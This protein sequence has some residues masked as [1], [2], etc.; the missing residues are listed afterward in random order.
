MSFV[1]L[2]HVVNPTPHHLRQPDTS[3]SHRGT[4]SP[5][6]YTTST[7]RVSPGDTALG[8]EARVHERRF[9]PLNWAF[10]LQT[11]FTYS[12][13]TKTLSLGILRPLRRITYNPAI[14]PGTRL[15]G[16]HVSY[17]PGSAYSP[18]RRQHPTI[19]HSSYRA[20][21][22]TP[23]AHGHKLLFC[24]KVQPAI[25][26]RHTSA[27][28]GT[29]CSIT[30]RALDSTTVGGS[31]LLDSGITAGRLSQTLQRSRTRALAPCELSRCM[32]ARP[33]AGAPQ[34]GTTVT[35]QSHQPQF[36]NGKFGVPDALHTG[37]AQR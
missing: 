25:L 36:H 28:P 20:A 5:C 17:L 19:D 11:F 16:Q 8:R 14:S 3:P 12:S 27:T 26:L 6:R 13:L 9:T 30:T 35:Q 31:S 23:E 15:S 10:Q 33:S 21:S 22:R 37:P 18:V 4:F 32:R 1:G 34:H 24:V 2:R 7:P 29:A